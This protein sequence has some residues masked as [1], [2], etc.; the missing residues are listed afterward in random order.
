LQVKHFFTSYAINRHKTT[1]LTPSYHAENYSP[2]DNRFDHR[3][4]L[5]RV[6]WPWQYKRIDELVAASQ[7]AVEDEGQLQ[8]ACSGSG[9]GAAAA[10][11]KAAGKDASGRGV[12]GAVG[13]VAGAGAG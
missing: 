12:D 6:T 13:A 4:F 9:S 5:Y 7:A 3:Q 8:R 2:D 11:A 10:G 1:V